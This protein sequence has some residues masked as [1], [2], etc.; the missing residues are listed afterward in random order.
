MALYRHHKG[1][2]CKEPYTI[3]SI[4]LWDGISH[5]RAFQLYRQLTD[6]LPKF[7]FPTS[8]RCATNDS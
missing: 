5:P 4:V 7:G 6:T 8:R 1:H 3:I 2:V